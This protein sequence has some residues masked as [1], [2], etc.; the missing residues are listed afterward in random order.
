VIP[1]FVA[2]PPFSWSE[3]AGFLQGET[4]SWKSV[5]EPPA[6]FPG[7]TIPVIV[8]VRGR[9]GGLYVS[10]AL[11]ANQVEI[12][13]E[14]CEDDNCRSW[15]GFVDPFRH[16]WYDVYYEIIENVAY[17]HPMLEPPEENQV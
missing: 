5:S 8:A 12:D 9:D 3:T 11:Y 2:Y 16:H 14:F 17:W 10:G 4:M 6:I 15:T 7:K 1:K 13:E